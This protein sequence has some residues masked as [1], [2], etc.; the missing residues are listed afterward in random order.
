MSDDFRISRLEEDVREIKGDMKDLR[1]EF[2]GFRAEFADFRVDVA[3]QFGS[4]KVWMVTTG[5]GVI[6]STLTAAAALARFLK[7]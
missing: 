5:L 3:K 2:T 4:L 1:K 6:V 7:P